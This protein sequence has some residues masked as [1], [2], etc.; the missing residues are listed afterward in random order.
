MWEKVRGYVGVSICYAP[1]SSSW[2]EALIYAMN[3]K[4]TR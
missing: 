4:C 1:L 3:N 2:H